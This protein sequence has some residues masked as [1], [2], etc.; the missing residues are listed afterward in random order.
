[1]CLMTG[2]VFWLP[3]RPTRRAFPSFKDSGFF[4]AAFVPGYSG[5]SATALHRSSLLRP[6]RAALDGETL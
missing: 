2:Q 4:E 6:S 5:G 3:V 1:M